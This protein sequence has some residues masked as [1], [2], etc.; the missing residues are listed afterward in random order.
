MDRRLN[1]ASDGCRMMDLGWKQL[2]YPCRQDLI[3]LCLIFPNPVKLSGRQSLAPDLVNNVEEMLDTVNLPLNSH[4]GD[5]KRM[6][7]N[8]EHS[9]C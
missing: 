9:W 8:V 7:C 6:P 2:I 4:S 5:C 3:R 1:S